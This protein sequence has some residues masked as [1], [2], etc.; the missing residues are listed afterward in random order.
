MK[1]WRG[2]WEFLKK[3]ELGLLIK[4]LKVNIYVKMKYEVIVG[5]DILK[6]SLLTKPAHPNKNLHS[7]R[8]SIKLILNKTFQLISSI[9]VLF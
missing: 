2:T 3:K 1:I 9:D 6:I 4:Y 7:S 8:F 5:L